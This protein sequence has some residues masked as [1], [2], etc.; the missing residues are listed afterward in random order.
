M[1]AI[2]S[3]VSPAAAAAVAGWLDK[4]LWREHKIHVFVGYVVD[5]TS[6]D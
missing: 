3:E 6:L 1:A 4:A 5:L 2:R